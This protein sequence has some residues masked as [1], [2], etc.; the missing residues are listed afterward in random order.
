M[1][2]DELRDAMRE[3][4]ERDLKEG[5]VEY[6]DPNNLREVLQPVERRTMTERM[7]DRLDEERLRSVKVTTKS[8]EVDI[9]DVRPADISLRDAIHQLPNICRFNGAVDVFYS[10]AQHSVLVASLLVEHHPAT[11]RDMENARYG[12]LHDLHEVFFGDVMAPIRHA[13]GLDE[14]EDNAQRTV[15]TR[16]G[17]T[18]PPPPELGI[19][20]AIARAIEWR[21]LR[22]STPLP[23]ELCICLREFVFPTESMNSVLRRLDK[24]CPWHMPS[25][26]F[27]LNRYEAKSLFKHVANEL[28]LKD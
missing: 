20:D 4:Q 26:F 1:I 24:V 14:L 10:V 8:R 5:L 3:N 6:Y 23:S 19:A 28:G 7:R 12:L 2:T 11:M 16:F 21:E 27:E 25:N 15:F 18:W 17:L 22:P 13:A 9:Y